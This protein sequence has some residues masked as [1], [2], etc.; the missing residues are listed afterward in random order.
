MKEYTVTREIYKKVV[1]LFNHYVFHSHENGIYKL[2][3][4][5]KQVKVANEMLNIKLDA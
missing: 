3:M 1:S 2:K 5:K 4:S